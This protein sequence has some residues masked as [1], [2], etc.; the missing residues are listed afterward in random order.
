MTNTELITTEVQKLI[1]T[2]RVS[3]QDVKKIAI[4]EAWRVLQIAVATV[5]QIIE[6]IGKDL[7]SPEKKA[8]AL[9]LMAEFYDKVFPII[10]LPFVPVILQPIIKKY[11][12]ALLMLL[13]SSTIDSMVTV[14][15]N[16]GVF[17][18]K[19]EVTV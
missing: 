6:A 3:L 12:K 15:R 7:S 9:S 19:L 2:V 8:L 11:V 10:M 16:T 17:T 14:F 18:T 5:V 4:G 1:Q 13:I